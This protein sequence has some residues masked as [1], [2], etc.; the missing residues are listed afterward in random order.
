[1]A[2]MAKVEPMVDSINEINAMLQQKK[3][4]EHQELLPHKLMYTTM[5]ASTTQMHNGALSMQNVISSFIK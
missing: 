3:H 1:V 4:F 2:G 5:M